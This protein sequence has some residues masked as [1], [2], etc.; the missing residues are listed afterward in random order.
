VD[1]QK[2]DGQVVRLEKI[3]DL[4][5]KFVRARLIKISGADLNLFEFDYDL[6][7]AAFFMNASGKV[8][9]RFGGRDGKGADTRN[10][11]EGLHFAMEAALAEH[12]KN[13]TSKPDTPVKPPMYVENFP[14]A[15]AQYKGCIHC[16]QVKEIQRAEAQKAGAWDRETIFSY[17]L[18][19]NIGITLDLAKGNLVR[20]VT[21]NSPAAKAG[22][23]PGD[24]VRTLNKLP[25][26][27]FADASYALHKAPLKGEIPIAFEHDGKTTD[28]TLSLAPKWRR[29]NI[30]WRPSLLDLLPSLTV[31][32]T[33]LTASEKKALGLDEKRLAFRQ[34]DPVH[35]AAKA[36][37]VQVND[38]IVGIDNLKLDMT[39]N[40]FLGYVRQNY[41][42]GDA[43]TLNILRNGKRLDLNA[44]LK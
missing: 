1:C 20:T 5:D 10:S 44:K 42:I 26:H 17:P 34:D 15:K 7:W 11:L 16:H 2:F 3:D 21:P 30:T 29:T 28:A 36:M 40:Q 14:I 37:G 39:M 9:G 12:R 19:E 33:D 38:V 41:L 27:S 4:A 25:V 32:G 35:S 18:P 22:V 8:Y 13:P 31:Y 43:I 6:T 23:Q 24:T